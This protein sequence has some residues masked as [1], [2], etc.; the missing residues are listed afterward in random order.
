MKSLLSA[1]S[2]WLMATA[3]NMTP[4]ERATLAT[5]ARALARNMR[6]TGNGNEGF[7]KG[8]MRRARFPHDFAGE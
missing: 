1:N 3:A 2:A 5:H 6:D 4:R 7:P 8:S